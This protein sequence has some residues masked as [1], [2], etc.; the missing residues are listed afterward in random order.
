M[1]K[2]I[3]ILMMLVSISAM[4][5]FPTTA[6]SGM[7]V[8]KFDCSIDYYL[9]VTP[10]PGYTCLMYINNVPLWNTA[11]EFYY[12]LTDGVQQLKV[13]YH[14]N[15]TLAVISSQSFDMLPKHWMLKLKVSESLSSSNSVAIT[16]TG[17]KHPYN[18]NGWKYSP[19]M[20]VPKPYLVIDAS[21]CTIGQS[22]KR[23]R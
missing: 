21:G 3:L 4:G 19:N 15:V 9:P 1:K 10:V 22:S 23:S 13:E 7:L 5:Q 2:I 6:P 18:V 11:G 17:G 12:T 20:V 8:Y 16:V 14:H